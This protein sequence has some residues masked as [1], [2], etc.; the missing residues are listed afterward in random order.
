MVKG[1]DRSLVSETGSEPMTSS[2][3]EHAQTRDSSSDTNRFVVCRRVL[4]RFWV[5]F[6]RLLGQ[7]CL[8]ECGKSTVYQH[9]RDGSGV[10]SIPGCIHSDLVF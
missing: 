9:S 2:A 6:R 10:E 8:V 5:Q 4:S 1:R 7:Q 3:R